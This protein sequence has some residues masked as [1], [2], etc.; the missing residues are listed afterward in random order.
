MYQNLWDTTL[1]VPR[2]KF[3]LQMLLEEGNKDLKSKRVP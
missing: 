1:A 2:K 3:I